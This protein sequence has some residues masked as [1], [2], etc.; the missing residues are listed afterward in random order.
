MPA[1]EFFRNHLQRRWFED[2]IRIQEQQQVIKEMRQFNKELAKRIKIAEA[3]L[4][5]KK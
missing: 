2:R 3:I 4:A 5:A 1:L